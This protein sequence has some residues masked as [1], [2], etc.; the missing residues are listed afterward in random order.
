MSDCQIPGAG[1]PAPSNWCQD[2]RA[3]TDAL[4]LLRLPGTDADKD[5][6]SQYVE[7]AC[8]LITA[9]LDRGDVP[10]EGDPPALRTAHALVAVELYR[11]KD[12]PFGVLNA[13]STDELAIRI[14]TDPLAGVFH[15]ILPFKLGF[16]VAG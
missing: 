3:L 6:L 5:R 8:Q 7:T 4:A 16:G 15:M 1:D 11:R 13:W 14:G 9:E 12:A 2:D 10:V